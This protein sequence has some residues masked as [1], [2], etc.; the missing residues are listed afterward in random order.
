ESGWCG[1]YY[2]AG[3]AEAKETAENGETYVAT[4]EKAILQYFWAMAEKCDQFVTFN[5][6]RFDVPFL[7]LRSAIHG[8]RPGKNLG[9][10]RYLY[11]M[12]RNAVHIDLCD[13]LTLY[14]AFGGKY[15]GL[16]MACQAFGIKSPKEGGMDGSQVG[17]A[18]AQGRYKEIAEYCL[19]DVI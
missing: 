8:I 5:G 13:Q 11:Q 7:L 10:A 17:E 4:S 14:G 3:G 18:Y 12:D 1:A 19:A 16:H 6:R 2:Q 15:M 9:K